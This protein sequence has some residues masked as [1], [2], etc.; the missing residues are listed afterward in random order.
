MHYF[1]SVY[2]VNQPLHVSGIFVANLANRQST[3]KGQQYQ[4]LYIYSTPPDN[5]LKIFPKHVE[6]D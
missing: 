5:G 4:L 6:V 1:S 2:F 3:K